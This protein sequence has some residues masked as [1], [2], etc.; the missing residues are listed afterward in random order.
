M[1]SGVIPAKFSAAVSEIDLGP[2][3]ANSFAAQL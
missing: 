3:D 2:G 1:A